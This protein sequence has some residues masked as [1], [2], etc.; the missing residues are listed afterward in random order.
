MKK[1]RLFIKIQTIFC[2]TAI[3]L[4]SCSNEPDGENLYTATGK[5]ITEYLQ[6]DPELSSLLCCRTDRE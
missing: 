6:E 2:V 1:N 4:T 5:T 3:A